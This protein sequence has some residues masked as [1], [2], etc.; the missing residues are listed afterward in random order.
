MINMTELKVCSKCN[1]EAM[2]AHFLKN[3]K[4]DS[5]KTCIDCR[6]MAKTQY[7]QTYYHLF[8]TSN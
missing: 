6:T 2:L 1:N 5:F 7:N 3:T 8:L 4:G